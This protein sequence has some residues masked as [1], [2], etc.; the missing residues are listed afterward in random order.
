V[1]NNSNTIVIYLYILIF[2]TFFLYYQD[3]SRN[4]QIS[5]FY[6]LHL[7]GVDRMRKVAF[8]IILMAFLGTPA[9]SGF[10][11][12]LG[13]FTN[14]TGA[15][16]AALISAAILNLMMIIFYLQAARHSQVL[17]KKRVRQLPEDVNTG[18]KGTLVLAVV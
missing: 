10:F 14:L 6:D 1:S 12:K 5:F 2:V 3:I 8:L 4:Q 15:C 16:A 7:S 13:V 18:S 17:R 9:T 11:Y